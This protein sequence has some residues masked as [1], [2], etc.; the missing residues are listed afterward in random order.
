MTEFIIIN[1]KDNYKMNFN[2]NISLLELKQ[3]I[4]KK[5]NLSDITKFNI[6]LEKSGFID[7]NNSSLSCPLSSLINS[8]S[9]SNP[10]YY[11]FC[12]NKSNPENI[13]KNNNCCSC[14]LILNDSNSQATNLSQ[15]GI[16]IKEKSDIFV[17][18]SCAKYC[19]NITLDNL[20][21]DELI[22]DTNFICQCDNE[23]N[24]KICK[25]SNFNLNNLIID[26]N[27]KN[28]FINKC[29]SL[30]I[31]K[32]EDIESFKKQKKM[33]ELNQEILKRDFDFMEVINL[34]E[35]RIESYK[36]KE[37]QKKIKEIIPQRPPS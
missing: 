30:I 9:H 26:Q 2:S 7:T 14:K 1:D 35:K 32:K 16:Q 19:H 25:F 12:F 6:F 5:I 11:F 24:K 36:D 22:T 18:S 31:K 21:S 29:I 8:L 4:S 17:C 37:F 28:E 13:I 23:S 20:K 33:K 15:I 34:L 3:L 10:P 27:E